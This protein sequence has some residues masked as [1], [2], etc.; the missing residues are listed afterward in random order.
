VKKKIQLRDKWR[1]RKRRREAKT[2]TPR[3]TASA[4]PRRFYDPDSFVDAAVRDKADKLSE[5]LLR[6][7][8]RGLDG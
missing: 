5:G 4:R 6:T 7:L 1:S 2:P 3:L 8:F